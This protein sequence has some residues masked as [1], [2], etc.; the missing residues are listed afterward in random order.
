MNSTL[1]IL[2]GTLMGLGFTGA[3]LALYGRY[4]VLPA[5]L[6]GPHTCQL[7]ESG[8]QALFRTPTAALLGV[9]NSALAVIYYPVLAAGLFFHQSLWALWGI[10]SLAFLM[11]IYLAWTLLSDHLE[12]RVCWLGHICNTVIWLILLIHLIP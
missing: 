9:P 11:T 8:C 2:L 5:F 10:S 6:T 12:C 1:H 7:E 4:R 3:C